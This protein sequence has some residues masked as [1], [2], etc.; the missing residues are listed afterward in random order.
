MPAGEYYIGDLC[1]VMHEEWDEV[2]DLF[3]DRDQ[4]YGCRQG[5][6]KLKDGRE[7]VSFNTR[8]GDGVYYDQTR[9]NEYG[10]DAGLIGCI[11]VS[12][13]REELPPDSVIVRFD[14]DFHCHSDGSMLRFGPIV[15]DTDP[16][17]EEDEE[18]ED[19]YEDE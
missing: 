13:I 16:G 5:K 17:V 7:F 12:D 10:V 15:I 11:K 19:E 18:Y 6:F 14:Q 8:Y 1:Y 2:C 4:P 3:F 9:M